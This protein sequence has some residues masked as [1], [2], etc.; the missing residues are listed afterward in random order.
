MA[1][2]NPPSTSRIDGI[3]IQDNTNKST[4][5]VF[6]NVQ[7]RTEAIEELTISTAAAAADSTGE[8]AAQIKFVTALGHQYGTA[9]CSKPTATISLRPTTTSTA[10]RACS[11][12]I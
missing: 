9:A 11:E 1:C 6:N 10:S 3:N 4:D 8:G 5:G 7:P 12:I 2:R